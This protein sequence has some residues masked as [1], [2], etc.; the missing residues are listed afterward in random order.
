MNT[1]SYFQMQRLRSKLLCAMAE[2]A[3]YTKWSAEYARS[4]VADRIAQLRK[5]ECIDPHVLTCAE[6]VSLDFGSWDGK[7]YLI[8]LWMY[9]FLK[10]GVKLKCIDGEEHEVSYDEQGVCN[11]DN[12]HRFGCLA[13]GIEFFEETKS[14]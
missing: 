4:N 6:A 5:Q 11:I 7:L 12:D 10:A 14:G 9:P 13:Y 1:L 3:V 2:S 8:P